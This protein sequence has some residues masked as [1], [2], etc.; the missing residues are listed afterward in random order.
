LDNNNVQI[1]LEFQVINTEEIVVFETTI[2]R[3]R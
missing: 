1:T 3:L 2:T